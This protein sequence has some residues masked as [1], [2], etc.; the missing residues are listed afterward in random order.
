M[1]KK[2]KIILDIIFPQFCLNCDKEGE[3]V[4]E[5]CLSL[6][7]IMDFIYCPLCQKPQRMFKGGVCGNH[8][9]RFLDGLYFAASYQDKLVKKMITQFKYEPYLKTLAPFLASLII[10]HFVKTK[11][12]KIF[13]DGENP[14]RGLASNGENPIFIPVPLT[15]RK[16]RKRGY[17]QAELLS[18]ILAG[19]FQRPLLTDT[20]IKI[21]KT[22]SQVGLS[23]R[24]RIKNVRGA[25]VVQDP[26]L[27]AGKKIFLVDDVFTTGST[28]E[29]C[30]LTLKAA[31]AKSVWGIT[32][33][34][35]PLG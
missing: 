34:R 30:A 15:N 18:Q 12:T 4:C 11:N 13:T 2:R 32:V 21:K 33:A 25:F 8:P 35:E 16:K 3:L 1:S 14:V 23:L 19:Y 31:G 27:I 28:M 6:I 17:N 22:P 5:D 26:F 10:T 24:E 7:E 20:L 9:P 29:E